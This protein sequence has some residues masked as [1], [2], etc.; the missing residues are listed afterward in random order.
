M[1]GCDSKLK[2]CQSIDAFVKTFKAGDRVKY[3][4]TKFIVRQSM[5]MGAWHHLLLMRES[6]GFL[7]R[8]FV[9]ASQ[10]KKIVKME[11]TI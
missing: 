3:R 7:V 10:C 2:K 6:D 11:A 9:D 8:G 4:S 5:R 1:T